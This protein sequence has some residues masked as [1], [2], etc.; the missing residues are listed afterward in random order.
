[1]HGFED[2][3]DDLPFTVGAPIAKFDPA[4]HAAPRVIQTQAAAYTEPCSK[5]NG[6]GKFV[7]YSGRV[8][9][10]CFVCGGAGTKTFKTAP[11]VRERA[12]ERR[13]ERADA[14]LQDAARA[15]DEYVAQHEAEFASLRAGAARGNDFC[16]SLLD[17][18]AKWGKLTDGQLA[19]VRRGIERDAER[20]AARAAERTADAAKPSNS[21]PNLFAVMQKHAHFHAAP[22]KLS[23]KNQDSLVWV[24]WNDSVVGKIEN[25]Q[26]SLFRAAGESRPAIEAMIAEFEVNPLVAARKYG[27]LSGRCCSCN[28]D[29]TN[30]ESIEAGIGPICAEKFQ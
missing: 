1:M 27:K 10:D 26:V 2:M 14:A 19:A 29:L 22:L 24:L 21:V 28:R 25:A 23:R 17:A 16:Q 8:V 20:A 9:G 11:A 3:A 13:A 6:R 12:A 5:C 30:P 7:S 15:R 4:V 18:F